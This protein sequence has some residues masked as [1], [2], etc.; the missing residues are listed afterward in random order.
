MAL[1]DSERLPLGRPVLGG[2]SCG[3]T[4]DGALQ[5]AVAREER[6]RRPLR[7]PRWHQAP[8]RAAPAPLGNIREHAEAAQPDLPA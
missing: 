6:I 7:L 8:P 4:Y 5:D 3:F 2:A 1:S